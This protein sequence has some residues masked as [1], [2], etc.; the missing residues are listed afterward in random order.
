M[1]DEQLPP[2]VT[3]TSFARV[4]ILAGALLVGGTAI[5]LARRYQRPD[6]P[7]EPPSPGMTTGSNSVTLTS[8]APMWNVIKVA[9]AEPA[10]PHW[11]DLIPARIMFD[12]THTSRIGSALAGRVTSVAVERGQRVTKGDTLFTVSSPNLAELRVDLER[13]TVERAT[14]KV[15]FDRVKNLVDA[16]SIPAKELQ[17]AQQQVIEADL[18]VKLAGQKLASLKVGG[19]GDASFTVTAPRDG[20]VVERNVTVGQGVDSS[21]GSMIAI[22]DL[23]DVWVVADPFESDVGALAPGTK[24]KV[25]IGGTAELDATVDQVSAVVDPERH[26]VPVR[27]KLANADGALRPNAYAQIRF[28]DPIAAKVALPASAVLSDGSQSYVY[29]K[30]E[31]TGELVRRNVVVGSPSGG[32]LPV[33]AGIEPGDQVV[34]QGGILLDNQIVLDN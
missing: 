17:T 19:G 15:S 1:S 29:R 22:A 2:P 33:L 16:G 20:V 18:A 24:A 31:R 13:A 7:K 11:T 14:A 27:V 23:A 34:V 32:S 25:L 9:A 8:D 3:K 10:Q 30:A 6:P 4:A 5:V 26:T 21:T 12:E 28:F